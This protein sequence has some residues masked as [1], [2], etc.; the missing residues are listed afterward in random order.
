MSETWPHFVELKPADAKVFHG[1]AKAAKTS[2]GANGR[3]V[4]VHSPEDYSNMKM[5]STVDGKAGYA[6]TR[7]GELTSVFKHKESSYENVAQ[8]AAEHGAVVGGA[9]HLSAFDPKLPKMYT[10]GG[11]KVA[12]RVPFDPDYKPAGWNMATQGKPDVV[13]MGVTNKLGKRRVYTSKKVGEVADYD[14]GMEKAARLGS[15]QL[16]KR[17]KDVR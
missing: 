15:Q 3:A 4:D 9:T 1:W 2:Q 11:F 13:F 17:F 16:K 12:G 5:F 6:V 7:S 10:K 14:A 8:R